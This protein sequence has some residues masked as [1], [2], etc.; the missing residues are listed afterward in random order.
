MCR[1]IGQH[2]MALLNEND[3]LFSPTATLVDWRHLTM[4]PHWL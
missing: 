2:G 1:A 4:E 3:I